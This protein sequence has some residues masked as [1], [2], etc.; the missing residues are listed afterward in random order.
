[1]GVK[2]AILRLS[3][4]TVEVTIEDYF[5]PMFAGLALISSISANHFF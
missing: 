2:R 1:M 3:G 5:P 4:V